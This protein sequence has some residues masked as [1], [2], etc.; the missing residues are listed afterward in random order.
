MEALVNDSSE[1]VLLGAT[2][3]SRCKLANRSMYQKIE[4]IAK[5]FEALDPD[6]A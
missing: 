6:L 2:T 3:A 4:F 1:L 5:L